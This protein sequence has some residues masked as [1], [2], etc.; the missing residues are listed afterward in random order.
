MGTAGDLDSVWL[1]LAR[2]ADWIADNRAA[3]W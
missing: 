2:L 3:E 1:H